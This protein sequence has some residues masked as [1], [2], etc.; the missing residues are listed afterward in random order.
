M[1]TTILTVFALTCCA[2]AGAVD[3]EL[4]AEQMDAVTAG[5]ASATATANA[6]GSEAATTSTFTNTSTGAYPSSPSSPTGGSA[7]ARAL[8]KILYGT[9]PN[10]G[11][12]PPGGS[13]DDGPQFASS[14]SS[15]SVNTNGAPAQ[16]IPAGTNLTP[17]Q[18]ALQNSLGLR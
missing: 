8:A 2:S 15:S 17:S 9:T 1:K 14:Q 10:V 18:A 7:A 6:V 16:T 11:G 12:T 13:D 3:I 4:A 5:S